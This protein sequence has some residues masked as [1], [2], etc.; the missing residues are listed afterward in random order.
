LRLH[1]GRGRSDSGPLVSLWTPHPELTEGDELP[2][3][4]VWAALDCPSI[5]AA[6]SDRRP[7]QP[8]QGMFDVLARQRLQQVAP[9]PLGEPAI[10]SAWVIERVGRKTLSGTAIHDTGGRLLVRADAL[11]V[12][13]PIPT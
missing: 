5:W 9:V 3:E 1:L 10:V 13:V 12:E 4:M 2:H 7:A 11:L 6:W 8:R